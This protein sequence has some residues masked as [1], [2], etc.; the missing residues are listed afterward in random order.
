ML[1]KREIIDAIDSLPEQISLE[2]LM[3]AVD[4]LVFLEEA[5]QGLKDVKQGRVLLAKQVRESL[6]NENS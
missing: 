2:Q 5:R 1:V 3:D 6:S 4:R